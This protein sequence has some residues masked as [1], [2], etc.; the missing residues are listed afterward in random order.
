LALTVPLMPPP[1][2]TPAEEPPI[3]PAAFCTGSNAPMAPPASPNARVPAALAARPAA[4]GAP[5]TMPA[6]VPA[7]CRDIATVPFSIDPAKP[8]AI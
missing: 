2:P 8:G 6:A 1:K 3:A 4:T 5:P 7:L